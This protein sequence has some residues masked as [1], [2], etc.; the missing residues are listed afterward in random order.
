MTAASKFKE[1]GWQEGLIMGIGEGERLGRIATAKKM[2]QFG[3]AKE[4]ILQITGLEI[5][6]ILNEKSI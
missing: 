4:E 3:I 1:G 5:A 2:L 6:V